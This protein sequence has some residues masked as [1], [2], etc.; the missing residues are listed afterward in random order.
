[1]DNQGS[2]LK[3]SRQKICA[4]GRITKYIGTMGGSSTGRAMV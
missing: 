4:Y 3:L 2:A 1:L